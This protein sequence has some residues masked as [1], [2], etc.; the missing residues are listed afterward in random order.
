MKMIGIICITQRNNSNSVV[1]RYDENYANKLES[2]YLE[3]NMYTEYKN[4][5]YETFYKY[6]KYNFDIY[7]KIKKLYPK[8]EWI[9][10]KN[11]IINDIKKDNKY[12]GTNRILNKIFIEEEMYDELFLN[13]C[14]SDM[15]SIEEYE[16][17]LLPKYKKEILN[18]YKKE[19]L[20][21]RYNT[22]RANYRK[23]A[24]KV[25]KV[26][27]LDDEKE[28]SKSLLQELNEKYFGARAAMLEEFQ[29]IIKNLDDYLK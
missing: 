15:S 29:N 12:Y 4:I 17:Y 25:N 13:V 14:N 23:H 8:E 22:S 26:I 1:K 3:N 27:Q 2:I 5:L 21:A 9:K 20:D 18:I 28:I 24:V 11:K 7:I 16:K 19:C 6:D 10:E